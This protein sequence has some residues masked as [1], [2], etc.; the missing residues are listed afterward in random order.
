MRH[1]QLREL[2]TEVLVQQGGSCAR[3]EI[4]LF[5]SEYLRPH[6]HHIDENSHNHARYNLKVVC[7][8]CHKAIHN[9][10]PWKDWKSWNDPV[11]EEE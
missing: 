8:P 7:E 4:P 6:L 1:D 11:E 2:R 5:Y 9:G 10:K 3:C